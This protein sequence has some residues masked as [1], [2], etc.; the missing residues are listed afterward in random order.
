ML[1]PPTSLCVCRRLTQ[2]PA[3]SWGG[4]SNSVVVQVARSSAP[5]PH[6]GDVLTLLWHLQSHVGAQLCTLKNVLAVFAVYDLMTLYYK[7]LCDVK[8]SQIEENSRK[9]RHI[10]LSKSVSS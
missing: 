3:W 6:L 2:P 9:F 7:V 4:V 1:P 10:A 8:F 5:S